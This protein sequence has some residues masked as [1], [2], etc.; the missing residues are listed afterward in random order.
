ML[1]LPASLPALSESS[2]PR[3]LQSFDLIKHVL[4][5]FR[6]P[7]VAINDVSDRV[8]TASPEPAKGVATVLPELS[9]PS[10]HRLC[11]RAVGDN[12]AVPDVV[13]GPVDC[14]R[15]QRGRIAY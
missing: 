1:D 9:T 10:E 13:L 3:R 11:L 4:D 2:L 15:G 5:H 12:A 8:G 6:P 7:L 14:S